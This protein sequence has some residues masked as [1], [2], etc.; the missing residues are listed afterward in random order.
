MRA[1]RPG[2]SRGNHSVASRGRYLAGLAS[3]VLPVYCINTTET[4]DG[5]LLILIMLY[6]SSSVLPLT[7]IHCGCSHSN[8]SASDVFLQ[9]VLEPSNSNTVINSWLT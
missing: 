5:V 2:Q 4:K 3:K 8:S 9:S 7:L 6:Y 1:G